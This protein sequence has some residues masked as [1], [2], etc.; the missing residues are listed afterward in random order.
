MAVCYLLGCVIYFI[1]GASLLVLPVMD[2][3]AHSVLFPKRAS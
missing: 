3:S 1:I 2:D